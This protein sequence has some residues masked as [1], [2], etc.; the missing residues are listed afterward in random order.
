MSPTDADRPSVPKIDALD[1][2][3]HRVQRYFASSH[4]SGES[5]PHGIL[6]DNESLLSNFLDGIVER[7]KRQMQREVE[8]SLSYASAV[9]S[10]C[11]QFSRFYGR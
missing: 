9:L 1:I 10:S 2:D 3:G 5:S 6:R 4:V 7:D 11:V 8:K